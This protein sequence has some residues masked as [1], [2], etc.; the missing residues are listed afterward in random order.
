MNDAPT[1]E[2][3]GA[4]L[5]KEFEALLVQF[6]Q[7]ARDG[8][9]DEFRRLDHVLRSKALAVIGGMP[10]MNP[11]DDR[12]IDALRD[13]VARLGTAA[14]EIQQERKLLKA[15]READQRIRLAYSRK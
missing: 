15:R 9:L 6:E 1:S 7:A 3:P 13:A 8:D 12:Y 11:T 2:D 14:G 5:L 10:D 4:D